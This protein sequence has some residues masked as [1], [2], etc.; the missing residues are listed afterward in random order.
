MELK[1]YRTVEG[2]P[3][4]DLDVVGKT[5]VAGMDVEVIDPV[6]VCERRVWVRVLSEQAAFHFEPFAFRTWYRLFWFICSRLFLG[7]GLCCLN[8]DVRT[9]VLA[10]RASRLTT[11]WDAAALLCIAR[12]CVRLLDIALL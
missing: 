3:D 11:S 2:T 10:V 8:D 1:S 4:V 7:L 9:V 6:E 5:K 12:C